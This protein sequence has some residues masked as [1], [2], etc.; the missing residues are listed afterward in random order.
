MICLTCKRQIPDDSEKCPHC[1]TAVFHKEQ[2][3]REIGF[4]RYQRWI[5]YAILALSFA[6]MIGLIV[7]IYDSNSKLLVDLANVQ[8]DLGKKDKELSA[9][10]LTLDQKIQEVQTMRQEME[11]QKGEL[12]GQVSAKEQ[13]INDKVAQIQKEVED[14]L[15]VEGRYEAAQ[16][17]LDGAVSAAKN[18]GRAVAGIAKAD[19]AKIPLSSFLP[20]GPDKDGDGLSDELEAALG[21]NASS[22]DTDSDGFSDRQE[23]SGGFDP[24]VAGGKLPIDQKFA[25]K[26]RGRL[27]LQADNNYL[28]YI[29]TDGKKY[30][31]GKGK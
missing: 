8:G 24:L 5:F 25:D 23:V 6:G 18:A 20:G 9:A 27:F 17:E 22:T 11:N 29:G 26:Q 15:E 10:K 16:A 13:E 2:L 14:R 1:G 31:I 7:K 3:A 21:S 12:S 4:R 28:W 19:I 30:L